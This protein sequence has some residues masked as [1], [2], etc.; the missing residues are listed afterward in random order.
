M[1]IIF[2]GVGD[3]G[4]MVTVLGGLGPLEYGCYTVVV[5]RL[6]VLWLLNV[7]FVLVLVNIGV[8]VTVL[9]GL[10]PLVD[11]CYTMVACGT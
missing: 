4:V 3:I 11:G 9:G 6:V 2:D 10:R 1:I 7:D 8:L 5:A